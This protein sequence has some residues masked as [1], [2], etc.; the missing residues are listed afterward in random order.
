MR[1]IG[2]LISFMLVAIIALSFSACARNEAEPGKQKLQGSVRI[3]GSSTVGPIS[4]AV[5]EEFRN[6]DPDVEVGVAIS[7]T[8]GGFKKFV[9]GETDIN[10][11]SRKVKDSE[12]QKAKENNIEMTEFEVAYDGI[13]VVVNKDNNWIDD[14]TV[15]DLNKI[16]GKDSTVKFWSEVNPSWPK[17][18][19]KLYGPGTDS[20][21]FDYFTEKINGK[22]KVI[23][24]DFTASEDDNTLVQ[25]VSGDKGAMGYFGIAYAEENADKVKILKINGIEPK[26]ETVL[27]KTYVL[28]RPL[29][30]Y[31]NNKSLERQEVKEFVKYYLTIAKDL[32]SEV[33]YFPLEDKKYAEGLNRIQ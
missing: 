21:T 18:E 19:I 12:L 2:S 8:G 23:R 5:A 7:G 22:E 24:P 13:A 20:G 30:I 26:H 25:G 15:E 29:Y 27:D 32:V 9:V 28:S 6:E 17:E 1:R 4:L 33:G 10:D 11:A 31:V 3:D 14:I 16:W